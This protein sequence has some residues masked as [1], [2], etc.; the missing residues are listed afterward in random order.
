M[1]DDTGFIVTHSDIDKLKKLPD[2]IENI[3]AKVVFEAGVFLSGRAAENA[4]ILE[5]PL[6]ASLRSGTTK[7]RE[8]KITEVHITASEDYAFRMHEE[9]TP[10]GPLN[11]GPNSQL[12][13][14]EPVAEGGPGGKY[15]ARAVDFNIEKVKS[16]IGA[17]L[18]S[19]IPGGIK[20][21][22]TSNR[23]GFNPAA[24]F[25]KARFEG[26]DPP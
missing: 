7:V 6:R 3:L 8:G 12:A 1:A 13:A 11:L 2:T 14:S 9:L 26:A 21:K 19:E 25:P 23:A 10:F 18:I 20:V 17:R 15:I 5:G 24:F 4:P 16:V 22:S